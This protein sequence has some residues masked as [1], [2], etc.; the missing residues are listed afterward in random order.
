MSK[1]NYN[2]FGMAICL[3]LTLTLAACGD[4]A[5][6]VQPSS[7]V[8]AAASEPQLLS[9][10]YSTRIT[11]RQVNLFGDPQVSNRYAGEWKL[12]L[13][14][15]NVYRVSLNNTLVTDGYY[16]VNGETLTFQDGQWANTC[17]AGGGV[18]KWSVEGES[19]TL[20]S[21]VENCDIRSFLLT[22]NSF[23]L[24]K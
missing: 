6:K 18:Y 21:E 8:S 20:T 7:N 12:E 15:N 19:L 13:D 14:K 5:A 11:L 3:L 17:K 22:T 10:S 16:Q 2:Y 23:I 4:N 9:G 24:S 1:I